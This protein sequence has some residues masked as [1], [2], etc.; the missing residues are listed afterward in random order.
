MEPKPFF[1]D[2]DRLC[3]LDVSV[4]SLPNLGK[5]ALFGTLIPDGDSTWGTAGQLHSGPVPRKLALFVQPTTAFWLCFAEAASGRNPKTHLA[6]R[7]RDQ[8]DHAGLSY[9]ASRRLYARNQDLN[10]GDLCV[11]G[12]EE[13][14][15][16]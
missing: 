16:N 11:S 2:L 4:V 6:P 13:P 8:P 3:D 10:S 14:L 15:Q 9:P 7:R 5:L 1:I 12:S